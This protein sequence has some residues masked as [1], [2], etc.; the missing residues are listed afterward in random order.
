MS[1]KNLKMTAGYRGSDCVGSS[2]DTIGD[3]IVASWGDWQS[4]HGG[5]PTTAVLVR[6]R[7]QIP[8]FGR[9]E[10]PCT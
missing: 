2:F 3:Q 7:A 6:A 5:Q 9:L 8:P 10:H 1:A 4:R